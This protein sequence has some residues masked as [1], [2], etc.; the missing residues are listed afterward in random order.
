MVIERDVGI[1]MD[2]GLVLRAD[3]FRPQTSEPVE[4]EGVRSFCDSYQELL[5]C[6]EGKLGAFAP[7]DSGQPA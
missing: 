7:A 3:V 6:I 2:D 4:H 5:G 1:P